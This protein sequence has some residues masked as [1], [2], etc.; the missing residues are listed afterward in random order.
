M[1]I[2]FSKTFLFSK[3]L[4]THKTMI[5]KIFGVIKKKLKINLNHLISLIKTIIMMISGG[6]VITI[7]KTIPNKRN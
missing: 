2:K 5:I 7:I 1:K 4:I 6:K 3:R